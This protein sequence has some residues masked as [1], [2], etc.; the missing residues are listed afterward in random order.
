[1]AL[2]NQPINDHFASFSI[3]SVGENLRKK[4]CCYRKPNWKWNI[5]CVFAFLLGCCRINSSDIMRWSVL[6]AV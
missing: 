2:L 5:Y 3:P 4:D 6:G 1:M